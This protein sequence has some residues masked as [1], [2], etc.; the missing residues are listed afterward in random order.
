[1]MKGK[2][3]HQRRSGAATKLLLLLLALMAG[4]SC[5]GS[6]YKVKPVV[7]A[8]VNVPTG[9]A[10]AGGVELRAVALLADEDS[11][12]LFEANLLLAGL[13]PVRVELSNES[14]APLEFKRVRFRLRAESG[15]DWKYRNAKQ[16][17]SRILEANDIYL[18]NPNS[19]A[20]FEAAFRA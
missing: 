3:S 15:K 9:R 8:P 20:A 6:L 16:A 17:V 18:Y 2:T 14:G 19:R 12:E 5:G 7:N 4:A 13:L 1:M 11:Q 10:A